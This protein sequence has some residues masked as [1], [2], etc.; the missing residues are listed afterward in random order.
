MMQQAAKAFDEKARGLAKEYLRTEGELLSLLSEMRS[1]R[2]FL[3]LG[4]TGIFD[5]CER[6][7][8]LSRAQ[9]FYFKSVAEKSED[10]PEI[11][12]AVVEGKLTLSQARRIVPVVTKENHQV[13]IAKA[14]E[15]PQAEL[16]REVTVVNPKAHLRERM[17]SIAPS[18][19]ELRAAVDRETEENLKVLQDLLSQKLGRPATLSDVLRAAA[20]WLREKLAPDVKPHRPISSGNRPAKPGRRPVPQW[21]KRGVIARDGRQCSY[22]GPEGRR[23]EQ[24]RWLH[25]HHKKEVARGGLNTQEN[26][27]ILCSGHH[28]LH[29]LKTSP[30]PHLLSPRAPIL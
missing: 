18:L 13:W 25:F 5:Y 12:Q 11:K 9:A 3:E 14:H 28:R 4:Y 8:G 7:L 26:L 15:L 1:Q 29:H 22:V 23:C 19:T 20:K 10:V 6:A 2:I 30:V 17:K 21:V 27:E 16:E 24:K